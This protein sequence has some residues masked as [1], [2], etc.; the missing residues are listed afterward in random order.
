MNRVNANLIVAALAAALAPALAP[1]LARAEPWFEVI[2]SAGKLHSG[3]VQSLS[4]DGD[5]VLVEGG[6]EQRL[7]AGALLSLA[8]QTASTAAP[9][10]LVDFHLAGGDRVRGTIAAVSGETLEIASPEFTGLAPLELARVAGVVTPAGRSGRWQAQ[11][12]RLLQ[13][14]TGMS[15]RI[16][17]DNGDILNGFVA[18][19]DARSLTYEVDAQMREAPLARV[20]AL[21]LAGAEPPAAPVSGAHVQLVSGTRLT[22]SRL[23][24]PRSGPVQVAFGQSELYLDPTAVRGI[25]FFSDCVRPLS[26]QPPD[27]FEETPLLTV[28][29]G[30]ALDRN[31]A[32]GPLSV[33]GRQFARGIGVHS[34]SVLRYQLGGAATALV[35]RFGLDDSAGLGAMVEVRVR[36]DGESRLERTITAGAGLQDP[37]WIDLRGAVALELMVDPGPDGAILDRFDWVEPVLI[38]DCGGAVSVE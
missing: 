37:L 13:E 4:L 34:R 22:V 17:L 1:A 31:V 27:A 30:Y 38:G 33:A 16:L 5:L 24:W 9:P 20:L 11:V 18:S 36:V 3:R 21:R 28:P 25:A 32:G 23:D 6:A 14:P 29:W 26:A 12:R 35:T 15:D 19:L 10:G 7:P 2:T 8:A